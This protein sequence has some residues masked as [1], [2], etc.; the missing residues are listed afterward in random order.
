MLPDIPCNVDFFEWLDTLSDDEHHV[1]LEVMRE[2]N[3]GLRCR[4]NRNPLT[5]Q[6]LFNLAPYRDTLLSLN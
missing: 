4:V 2:I 1:V 6:Q 5:A 3:R